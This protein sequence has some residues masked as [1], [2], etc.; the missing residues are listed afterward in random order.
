MRPPKTI[1]I[2][3]QNIGEKTAD[4]LDLPKQQLYE[5]PVLTTEIITQEV[6]KDRT[7]F[8]RGIHLED[9]DSAFVQWVKDFNFELEGNLVPV[10]LYSLQRFSEFMQNWD[11][12]DK[13]QHPSLPIITIT[14]ESPAKQGTMLGAISSTLPSGE[15]FPLYKI[16][17]IINGKTIFEY[18]EVPQPTYVDLQYKINVFTNH[19]RDVN[20]FNE[21]ILQE[22]RKPQNSINVYGHN[23]E[24]KLDDIVDNNKTELEER[25][26]YKHMFVINLRAFLLDEKDFKVKR[27]LNKIGLAIEN[28]NQNDNSK[29]CNITVITAENECDTCLFFNFN[30]KTPTEAEYKLPFAVQLTYDNQSTNANNVDYF[31]NNSP[32]NLPITLNKNDILKIVLNNEVTKPVQVKIC[33][34]KII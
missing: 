27:S 7:F 18:V 1:T 19:Q 16:P 17:K 3:K 13:T 15:T 14:K 25:R 23:M 26:Y 28:N 21:L 10:N 31:V 30:K 29:K 11:I 12:L 24:L 34:T 5:N 9:L 32:S 6:I 33:G 4:I 2:K 22:F 20:K 8:P